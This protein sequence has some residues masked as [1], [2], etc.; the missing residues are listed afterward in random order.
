ME[1]ALLGDR[2]CIW[3]LPFKSLIVILSKI[4][5]RLGGVVGLCSPRFYLAYNIG[6][7]QVLEIEDFL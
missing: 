5:L 7:L 4:N 2:N 1:M 6:L 3:N